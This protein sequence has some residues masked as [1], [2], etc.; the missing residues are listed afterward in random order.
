VAIVLL[1]RKGD[2]GLGAKSE[3]TAKAIENISLPLV[4]CLATLAC[5]QLIAQS[6]NSTSVLLFSSLGWVST[7]Q[8][9]TAG[10]AACTYAWSNQNAFNDSKLRSVLDS[11]QFSSYL[12]LVVGVSLV[13]A[14]AWS[15]VFV[16]TAVL[17]PLAVALILMIPIGLVALSFVVKKPRSISMLRSSAVTAMTA[18]LVIRGGV[19]FGVHAN[20]MLGIFSD[21]WMHWSAVLAIAAVVYLAAS[22]KQNNSVA[23]VKACIAGTTSVAML[24]HSIGFEFG[25]CFVLAPMILGVSLRVFELLTSD[26]GETEGETKL[27]QL[28][29]TANALVLG[30]GIGGVLR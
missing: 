5:G 11:N 30:S 6:F 10:L 13:I 2:A 26:E 18:Y 25:Y 15:A 12:S 24:A 8:I 7:L 1:R 17:F 3:A 9:F 29:K 4:G 23:R 22:W 16:Q 21:V 27:S 28:S 19:E 20:L 14:A